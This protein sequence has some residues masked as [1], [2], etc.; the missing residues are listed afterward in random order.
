MKKIL[1]TGSIAYDHLLGFDGKFSDSIIAEQLKNLSIS[2]T[3]NSHHSDFGGCGANIAYNLRLL[4]ESPL[5]FGVVGNDFDRYKVWLEKN[6]IST[7]EVIIDKNHPTAQAFV[8]TDVEHHQ[9]AIFSP[10]AMAEHEI[11]IKLRNEDFSTVERAI[12]SPEQPARMLYLAKYF[13]ENSLSFIF[14]P[15]QSIPV[16]SRDDLSFMIEKSS[17][18]ILNEYECEILMQKLGLGLEDLALESGFLIKTLGAEGCELYK[19]DKVVSIPAFQDAIVVDATGC[20]DAFRAGL[21]HGLSID[22]SLENS[23]AIACTVASFAV[24]KEGTQN[25]SFTT[26]EIAQRLKSIPS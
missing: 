16:L 8:L 7:E 21:L 22:E 25:H 5:L 15:G 26:E 19:N 6:D 9:I 13:S 12:L 18:M 17:G 4:D 24:E 1:V 20:G 2:F 10:A 23:C 11:E 14:D 3:A